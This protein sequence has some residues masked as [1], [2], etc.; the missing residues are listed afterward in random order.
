MNLYQA[1]KE[2]MKEIKMKITKNIVKQFLAFIFFAIISFAGPLIAYF[3]I[4]INTGWIN[5]LPFIVLFG[6]MLAASFLICGWI[7]FW[8]KVFEKWDY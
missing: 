3:E 4:M 7:F 1:L 8:I 2:T 6:S 5:T